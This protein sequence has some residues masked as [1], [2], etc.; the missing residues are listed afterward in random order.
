[1]AELF[2]GVLSLGEETVAVLD[3]IPGRLGAVTISVMFGAAPTARFPVK[4]QVTVP[5]TL[6]HVQL[7]PVALTKVDPAGRG[8]T[9]FT[10]DAGSGPELFT[11]IV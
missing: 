8:S 1:V 2:P 11:P 5:E 6:L 7:V 10:A 4:L 9:T 3:T